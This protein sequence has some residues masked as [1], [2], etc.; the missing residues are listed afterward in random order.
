MPNL[1]PSALLA[2]LTL[3]ALVFGL[4]VLGMCGVVWKWRPKGRAW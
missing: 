4:P 2:W 1:D 3:G